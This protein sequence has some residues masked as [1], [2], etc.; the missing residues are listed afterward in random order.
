LSPPLTDTLP[1]CPAGMAIRTVDGTVPD[2]ALASN[3]HVALT[4]CVVPP[5][6]SDRA[7]MTKTFP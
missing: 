3:V 1:D 4:L 2:P 5:E 7:K 6:D